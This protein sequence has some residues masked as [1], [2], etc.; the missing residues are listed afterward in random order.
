MAA[1]VAQH[2]K[3]H[4]KSWEEFWTSVGEQ[5]WTVPNAVPRMNID[6]EWNMALGLAEEV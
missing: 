6:R 1:N 2:V 5:V 4:E 3:E